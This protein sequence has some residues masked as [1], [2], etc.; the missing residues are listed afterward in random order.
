MFNLLELSFFSPPLNDTE[1][2]L[3]ENKVVGMKEI[4]NKP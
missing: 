3:N 4:Y 2:E 1:S